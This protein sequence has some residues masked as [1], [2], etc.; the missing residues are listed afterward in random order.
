MPGAANE[1]RGCCYQC[2]AKKKK[3]RTAKK[4]IEV[5]TGL[6]LGRV[7]RWLIAS[8]RKLIVVRSRVRRCVNNR[9]DLDVLR[10]GFLKAAVIGRFR[11][12]RS[13]LTVKSYVIY[14][15]MY[16]FSLDLSDESSW[17]L[18]PALPG[19][20]LVVIPVLRN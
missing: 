8:S 19:Q 4:G 16:V 5:G 3:G 18:W 12:H 6:S 14:R 9:Q 20:S 10:P 11:I 13:G 1:K 17:L 2:Y 7:K 15:Y